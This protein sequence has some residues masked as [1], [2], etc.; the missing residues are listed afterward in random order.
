MTSASPPPS[1]YAAARPLGAAREPRSAP[2]LVDARGRDPGG[3]SRPPPRQAPARPRAPPAT[4]RRCPV[5]RACRASSSPQGEHP[6]RPRRSLA[7]TPHAL[8]GRHAGASP[9]PRPRHPRRARPR[10]RSPSRRA[11]A[12]GPPPPRARDPPPSAADAVPPPASHPDFSPPSPPSFPPSVADALGGRG[13]PP[14]SPRA[15]SSVASPPQTAPGPREARPLGE[16]PQDKAPFASS[17][18]TSASQHSGAF[19]ELSEEEDLRARVIITMEPGAVVTC[20]P[21]EEA[22]FATLLDVVDVRLPV[23]LRVAGVGSATSSSGRTRRTSTS[24]WIA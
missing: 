19:C 20:T 3:P 10:P 9:T 24:R 12:R 11:G 6:P 15:V 17:S 16:F 21:E 8:S 23:T 1:G 5:A 7:A 13:K 4:R 22:I 2:A 18:A 14:T